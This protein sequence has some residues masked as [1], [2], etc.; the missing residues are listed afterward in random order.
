M[1]LYSDPMAIGVSV[2]LLVVIA[3]Y[4]AFLIRS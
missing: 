4:A 2:A 3:G 1:P